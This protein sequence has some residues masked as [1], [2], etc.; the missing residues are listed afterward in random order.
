MI[1]QDTYFKP[2]LRRFVDWLF[3]F[4]VA[5]LSFA[6]K[7]YDLPAAL[8]DVGSSRNDFVGAMLGLGLVVWYHIGWIPMV[9]VIINSWRKKHP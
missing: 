5:A 9:A 6:W 1:L 3:L 2:T 8:V 4:T 7:G